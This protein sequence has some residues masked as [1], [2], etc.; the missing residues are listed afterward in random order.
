MSKVFLAVALLFSVNTWANDCN[1]ATWKTVSSSSK[2]AV[3]KSVS[4]GEVT[5]WTVKSDCGDL[6]TTNSS[7]EDVSVTVNSCSYSFSSAGVGA[8]L[9][10]YG[11]GCECSDTMSVTLIRKSCR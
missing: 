3:V 2:K 4:N 5:K 7:Q 1:K 10:I 6:T 8:G 11:A 9:T